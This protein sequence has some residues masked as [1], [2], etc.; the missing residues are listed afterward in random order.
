MVV[1]QPLKYQDPCPLSPL[2]PT[3]RVIKP[4]NGEYDFADMA[5]LLP[6]E[7]VRIMTERTTRV[8]AFYD[9][10]NQPWKARRFQTWIEEIYIPL[11]HEHHDIEETIF[12]PFFRKLGAQ[13]FDAQVEDHVVLMQKLEEV[14]KAASSNAPNGDAARRA[15]ADMADHMLRHLD[16]EEQFWPAELRKH[17]PAKV[18]EVEKLILAE[19]VKHGASF[20]IMLVLVCEAMG[21]N[22]RG[23][24]PAAGWASAAFKDKFR[25]NLPWVV[26]R[27]LAPAWEKKW[28]RYRDVLLSIT[29]DHET[30]VGRP[31]ACCG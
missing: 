26:R 30:P 24:H 3:S 2:C 14:R 21:C 8:L 23:P 27:L 28:R 12:F 29:E 4:R 22:L 16:E 31:P 6:H 5:F 1:E 19:G 17:G 20:Q 10:V 11:I 9:P 25:G 7:V 18:E 13:G 15:F